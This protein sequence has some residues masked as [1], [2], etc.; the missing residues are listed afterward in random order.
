MHKNL[1]FQQFGIKITFAI[2]CIPTQCYF[3]PTTITWNLNSVWNILR[4]TL[5][6]KIMN[7]YAIPKAFIWRR[8]HSLMGLWLV[9]FL[10]IH[11]LTNSQA[12]L[13]IGDDGAGFIKSANDLE[14][15]PYLRILEIIFLAI[16]FAIHAIWG[17]AYLFTGKFNSFNTDGSKPSLPEYPRNQ[18]YTWQR[19]T[20]WILLV[21]ITL[22]VVHMRFMEA[23][24]SVQKGAEKYFL[25][26]IENDPGLY[27]LAARL[28]F[29]LYDSNQASRQIKLNTNEKIP[30]GDSPQA[31]LQLQQQN[32]EKEWVAAF[33]KLPL[34]HDQ[35][36]AVAKNFGTAELLMVR[37][38]F[39]MP[40]MLILY[41]VLVLSSCFHAFNGFWTFMIKWGATLSPSSQRRMRKF[42]NIFMFLVTFMGLAAI[43][44]T[45]WINLK[46]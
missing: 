27:T 30:N 12:A 23:P 16:P 22:H 6:S 25:V 40:L 42:A 35:V 2:F 31:L 17:I 15:L 4:L 39:K 44:G 7:T 20:S 8:L 10:F 11:L 24:I 43:W 14:A 32:Q 28:D 19:I 9:L 18:A 38:T 26:R 41:T 46:Q 5:Y 45:Y 36:I 21:L 37:N 3:A 29:N 33:Q 34:N 13:L 1:S